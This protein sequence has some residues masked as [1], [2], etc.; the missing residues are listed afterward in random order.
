MF[1]LTVCQSSS[2]VKTKMGAQWKELRFRKITLRNIFCCDFLRHFR[3]EAN[4]QERLL[5]C[6]YGNSILWLQFYFDSKRPNQILIRNLLC[7]TWFDLQ[8]CETTRIRSVL[9][10]HLV[11][12]A[13]NER[14][15]QLPLEEVGTKNSRF[16]KG[17]TNLLKTLQTEFPS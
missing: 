10:K 1:P 7:T 17:C 3:L 14:G 5:F 4:I 12:S 15:Y 9:F 8:I 6:L 16:Q 2:V 11:E 13:N